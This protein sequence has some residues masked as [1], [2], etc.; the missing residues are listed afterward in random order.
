MKTVRLKYPYVAVMKDGSLSY[1]GNQ[2]W[3]SEVSCFCGN[4]GSFPQPETIPAFQ[5]R[6]LLESTGG[7]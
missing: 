3:F 1:G 2:G 7:T 5:N 6:E 4:N